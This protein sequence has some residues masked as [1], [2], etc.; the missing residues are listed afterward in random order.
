M[1]SSSNTLLH[2][3]KVI[4]GGNVFGWSLDE[5]ASSEILDAAVEGGLNCFDTADVYS[6]WASGNK[7]G[8]SET[9]IGNWL[10]RNGKR[11][12]VLI[13][14]KGGAPGAPGEF[15]NAK[16][17]AA[18]LTKAVEG[19]LRR[20]QTDYIDLYYVHYD[21]KVT[22]PEETLTCFQGL[23]KQGK[24]KAIAASNYSPE[25]LTEALDVSASKGLP[26]FSALQTLYNL[27]EREPFE[28]TLQ[29]LCEKRNVK[30]FTY[31]SLAHG[32]LS[33]KYRSEADLSKS[34]ARGGGIAKYLNPRGMRILDA[35]ENVSK[36]HGATSA[37]VALAW[38]LTRHAIGAAVASATNLGQLQ[39]LV[40]ATKLQL[41]ASE[42]TAL[43]RASEP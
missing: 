39:D 1:P 24:I 26:A 36:A 12:D 37:Q 33:G 10:K 9:I 43:D 2:T 30:V 17:T 14:T 20:L 34:A 40:T 3:P 28:S 4:L 25:R 8:E 7:G 6:H 21:D 19:S 5:K 42:L 18:Y 11:R 31:F 22:P 13:H 38:L 29:S 16:L 35:L 23:M 32:F 27:Y 15:A 41:D